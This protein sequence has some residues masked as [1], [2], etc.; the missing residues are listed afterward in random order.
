MDSKYLIIQNS[1]TQLIHRVNTSSLSV[2]EKNLVI[3]RI[4]GVDVALL[5]GVCKQSLRPLT[6][7]NLLYIICFFAGIETKIIALIFAIELGTVY[8]VRYRLRAY[9]SS[10]V[11]LPF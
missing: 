8:S 5:E 6:T 9:F 7:T 3:E 10:N 2:K 11:I 4:R 1:F